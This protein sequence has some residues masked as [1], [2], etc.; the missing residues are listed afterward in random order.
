LA[1]Q[2]FAES[3][4]YN[5]GNAPIWRTGNGFY[6]ESCRRPR[7]VWLDAPAFADRLRKGEFDLPEYLAADFLVVVDDLG[8]ARD[9]TNF[10]ADGLY[11][12]CNSRLGKWTVFTTNLRLN[13][14][15]EQIDPRVASRLIRDENV[16]CRIEAPDYA[17]HKPAPSAK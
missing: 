6:D 13:E 17:L 16:L 10:I 9:K 8:A 7:C 5:P 11:R 14:V 1:R 4:R 15:A 3:Q 2:V 12:L